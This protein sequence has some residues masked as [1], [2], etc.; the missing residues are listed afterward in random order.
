MN[1]CNNLNAPCF[2]TAQQPDQIG[3]GVPVTPE[4]LSRLMYQPQKGEWGLVR[5]M[6]E[7]CER[8]ISGIDQLMVLG[9]MVMC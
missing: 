6:D 5:S 4:E 2:C 8:I 3:G 1:F 9:K 7:E